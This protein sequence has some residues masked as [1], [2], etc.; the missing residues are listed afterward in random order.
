MGRKTAFLSLPAV[1]AAF[2]PEVG[3]AV[4]ES[5]GV[6]PIPVEA[7]VRSTVETADSLFDALDAQSALDRLRIRL[8]GAPND[9]EARWRAAR[10]A[11]ALAVMTRR[12]PDRVTLLREGEAHGEHALSARPN[13]KEALIWSAAL[14]GRLGIETGGPRE[15][16]RLG[17]EVW[18]F[19]HRV[20]MVDPD[21]AFAHDVLGKLNQEVRK[22]S[23]F[24]RLVART[25]VG[26]D[27]IRLSTWQDAE[28]HLQA[29]IESDG[30]VVLFFLDLGETYLHQDKFELAR[31]TFEAGLKL[32]DRFPPDARFKRSIRRRLAELAN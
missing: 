8:E 11:L 6:I 3:W 5:P 20:L 21:N 14:K 22:L 31:E 15:K 10:A 27:A 17:Q 28:R 24:K 12:G 26:N 32:P 4:Q 13:H 30:K 23:G 7:L 9:F 16:S 1:L 25:F 18:D 2:T 29:A 19:T